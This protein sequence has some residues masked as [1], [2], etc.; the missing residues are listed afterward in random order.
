MNA[1]T[2]IHECIDGENPQNGKGA[3]AMEARKFD[4][5]NACASSYVSTVRAESEARNPSPYTCIDSVPWKG[6][7][8]T[9]ALASESANGQCRTWPEAVLGRAEPMQAMP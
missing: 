4:F 5:S 8:K 1:L 3:R 6:E 7:K 9:I 2:R